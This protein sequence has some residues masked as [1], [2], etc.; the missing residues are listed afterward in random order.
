MRHFELS[1]DKRGWKYRQN[2]F[3]IWKFFPDKIKDERGFQEYLSRGGY[4]PAELTFTNEAGTPADIIELTREGGTVRAVANGQKTFTVSE[5]DV[6]DPA[7]LVTFLQE[8]NGHLTEKLSTID[9]TMPRLKYLKEN[10]TPESMDEYKAM[11]ADRMKDEHL[12]DYLKNYNGREP[13]IR[14]IPQSEPS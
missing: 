12:I 6:I 7:E 1:R 10:G 5:Y 2:K 9:G 3:D 13:V 4:D 8:R 14:I 11:T